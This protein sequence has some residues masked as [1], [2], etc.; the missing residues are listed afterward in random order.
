[1]RNR[2]IEGMRNRIMLCFLKYWFNF[3]M[4]NLNTF[5][6]AFLSELGASRAMK[7]A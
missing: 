7:G 3:G 6:R 4:Y 2:N 1:M 5:S